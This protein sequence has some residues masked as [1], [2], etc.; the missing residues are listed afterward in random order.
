[1]KHRE[2]RSWRMLQ[3]TIANFSEVMTTRTAV[4]WHFVRARFP[5]I[6]PVLFMR[7]AR[8]RKSNSAYYDGAGVECLHSCG[9]EKI[10]DIW[11]LRHI[12]YNPQLCRRTSVD[13]LFM[14]QRRTRT[15]PI[16]LYVKMPPLADQALPILQRWHPGN[17]ADR[18]PTEIQL[19]SGMLAV[20]GCR[21][22][23]TCPFIRVLDEWSSSIRT[24]EGQPIHTV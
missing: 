16:V 1:M 15:E 11:M 4:Y 5:G 13:E 20:R 6:P 19:N 18:C 10:A 2:R 12:P 24:R 9:I 17:A 8:Q 21:C 14:R 23:S 7:L 22:R 3:R